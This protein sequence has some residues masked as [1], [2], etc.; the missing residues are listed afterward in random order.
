MSEDS[1]LV[2]LTIFGKDILLDEESDEYA[3]RI[4]DINTSIS[5][6]EVSIV[7]EIRISFYSH[8]SK[9]SKMIRGEGRFLRL[10]QSY[11]GKFIVGTDGFLYELIKLTLGEE[12]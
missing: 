7:G 6:D 3:S 10:F 12:F 5:E 9:K 11:V 8:A 2:K 4:M 1:A